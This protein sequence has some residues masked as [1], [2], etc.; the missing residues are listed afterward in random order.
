MSR[1][2]HELLSLFADE[3][4]KPSIQQLFEEENTL[5]QQAMPDTKTSSP[6]AMD[7]N[8]ISHDEQEVHVD[9]TP[10]FPAN[11]FNDA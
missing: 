9:N 2:L 3:K 1:Q 11:R 7:S 8:S 10:T 4:K 5:A 6:S